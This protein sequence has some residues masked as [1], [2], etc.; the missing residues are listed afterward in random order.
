[1]HCTRRQCCTGSKGFV[2]PCLSSCKPQPPIVLCCPFLQG[3]LRNAQQQTDAMRP[4]PPQGSRYE[5]G[6]ASAPGAGVVPVVAAAS[7]APA[8]AAGALHGS[9]HVSQQQEAR[10]RTHGQQQQ[11]SGTMKGPAV[12]REGAPDT[13][14][15]SQIMLLKANYSALN[16]Q[17]SRNVSQ[18]NHPIICV[19][20]ALGAFYTAAQ[21]TQSHN[22]EF[23]SFAPVFEGTPC[24]GQLQPYSFVSFLRSSGELVT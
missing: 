2:C 23:Q 24:P 1:V 5:A 4:G 9:T 7:T 20:T 18:L 17:A 16:R 8:S 14:T 19:S 15:Q 6:Q 3:N 22:T 13:L 12:P 11:S 10:A 21:C